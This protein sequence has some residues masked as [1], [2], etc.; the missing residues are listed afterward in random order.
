MGDCVA[1]LSSVGG[2]SRKRRAS[3]VRKARNRGSTLTVGTFV[4]KKPMW[5]I[6]ALHGQAGNP[7]TIIW[8]MFNIFECKRTHFLSTFLVS[9]N[10]W[11]TTVRIDSRYFIVLLFCTLLNNFQVL[12]CSEWTG[13]WRYFT[14]LPKCRRTSTL[15]CCHKSPHSSVWV[16]SH[17]YNY[18]VFYIT[19]KY[20]FLWLFERSNFKDWR[21][22]PY[23]WS[24]LLK[25]F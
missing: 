6:T 8:R 7:K 20:L 11:T 19:T 5:A 2:D 25:W 10:I 15:T 13:C 12:E 9:P 21:G 23:R 24:Q 4:L 22:K 16:Y 17:R 14:L 3:R 18:L 1:C